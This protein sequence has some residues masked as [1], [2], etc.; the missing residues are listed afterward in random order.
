MPTAQ[1]S[2]ACA[3]RLLPVPR[4]GLVLAPDLVA[5]SD[6]THRAHKRYMATGRVLAGP[7]ACPGRHGHLLLR[8][9]DS[10]NCRSPTI[11]GFPLANGDIVL[12]TGAAIAT[13]YKRSTPPDGRSLFGCGPLGRQLPLGGRLTVPGRGT[14]RRSPWGACRPRRRH[15]RRQDLK[16]HSQPDRRRRANTCHQETTGVVPSSTGPHLQ[17]LTGCC[18]AANLPL[19]IP[20]LL[21]QKSAA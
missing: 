9:V 4:T 6:L 16:H 2:T 19:P 10:P 12:L 18:L 20:R 13:P 1:A 11:T 15:P 3:A 8:E 21:R 7:S 14:P 5:L 17:F